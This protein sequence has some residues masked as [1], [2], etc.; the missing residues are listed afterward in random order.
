MARLMTDGRI[1]LKSM[2]LDELQDKL[3]ELG[4]P[5][6]RARQVYKWVWQRG[7]SDFM[8]MTNIAKSAR[9]ELAEVFSIDFLVPAMRLDSEDG[10][11]KYV[12]EVEGGHHIESVLIPDPGIPGHS[13]PRMTLC[14]SSQVGCAMACSFCLTGDLGL[15]RN[16]RPAEIINQ[17]LQVQASLPEGQRITNLVFMGMGE[18]LHNLTNLLRALGVLLDEDG[19]NFSHRKVTISTVGLVPQMLKLAAVTPVN[20]AVSLNATTEASRAQVMPITRRYSLDDLMAGCRAFPLPHAK[21]ITFEYVMMHGF[22][23]TWDD[24][25]RLVK[26]MSGVKSKVN[27]IPYNENP[28][29]DILRPDAAHVKAFQHFLVSRGVQCSIRKTRGIDVSAA[30]GQL[31][32]ATAGL[33]IEEANLEG[34]TVSLDDAPA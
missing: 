14:M 20:L 25:A 17:A 33:R 3:V 28:Q 15:T 6:F 32:K 10:T 9:A 23:D 12:W 2:T 21:R 18:P 11:T 19:L 26:L 30:C 7:V 13:K 29:R 5:R 24:A 16:L 22:N 34:P 4:H 8:E 27:L 31:G 1:D